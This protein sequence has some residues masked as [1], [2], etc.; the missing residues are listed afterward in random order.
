MLHTRTRARQETNAAFFSLTKCNL[1]AKPSQFSVWDGQA[2]AAAG[3]AA[4][5]AAES[6][7]YSCWL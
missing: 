7:A 1:E 6:A 5:A 3:A 2:A 4:A